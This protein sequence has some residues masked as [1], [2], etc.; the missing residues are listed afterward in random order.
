MKRTS[1]SHL[2]NGHL[3]VL[4]L[5]LQLLLKELQVVLRCQWGEG[6]SAWAAGNNALG[7]HSKKR[8]SVKVLGGD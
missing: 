2:S 8:P 3:C 4:L 1:A 6:C 5:L 7:G